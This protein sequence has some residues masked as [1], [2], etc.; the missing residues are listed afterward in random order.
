MSRQNG[1]RR[2]GTKNPVDEMGVDEMGVNQSD[3]GAKRVT[4]VT[5][6]SPTVH[7]VCPFQQIATFRMIA[8][9]KNSPG[10]TIQYLPAFR[11]L[12]EVIKRAAMTTN[13]CSG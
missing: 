3:I 10:D 12:S 2:N 11:Y 7:I 4:V 8:R 1:N 13:L 5:F 6:I 9:D